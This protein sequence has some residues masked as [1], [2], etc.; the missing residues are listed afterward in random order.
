MAR[1]TSL[2]LIYCAPWTALRDIV[3]QKEPKP[4]VKRI[5]EYDIVA[6]AQWLVWPEECRYVYKEC[7]KKD[8]TTHPHYWEPFSKQSW[9]TWKRE[10]GY[11]LASELYDDHTKGLA[12]RAL[13]RMKNV[14]E[15]VDEEGSVGSRSV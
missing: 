8:V 7:M 14:Q 2:D 3:P 10:L 15:E 9:A 12:R 11:V 13:E 1:L 4:N 5:M 6:A